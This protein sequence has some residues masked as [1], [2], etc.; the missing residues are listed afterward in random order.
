MAPRTVELS[1]AF[2]TAA[3]PTLQEPAD[4]APYAALRSLLADAERDPGRIGPARQQVLESLRAIAELPVF[5]QGN[6]AIELRDLLRTDGQVTPEFR[7]AAV[8][9]VGAMV[10]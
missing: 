8:P 9:V 10:R 4:P 5:D 7:D 3:V 6:E 2:R 1:E